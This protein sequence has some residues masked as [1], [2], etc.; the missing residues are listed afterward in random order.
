MEPGAIGA[1]V[2]GGN[3]VEGKFALEFGEGLFLRPATGGAVL[4]HLRGEREIGRH[5]GIFEV[6]VVG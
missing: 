1:V 6:T 2:I 4:Q 3:Q 5:R